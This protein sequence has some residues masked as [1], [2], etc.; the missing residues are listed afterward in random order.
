MSEHASEHGTPAAR[1]TALVGRIPAKSRATS[2]ETVVARRSAYVLIQV[3]GD[4][5]A[6][7]LKAFTEALD[8]VGEAVVMAKDVD[9]RLEGKRARS[10][11]RVRVRGGRRS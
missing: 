9:Q 8:A 6:D 7:V 4:T 2:E 1:H 11:V 10:R 3:E 5:G